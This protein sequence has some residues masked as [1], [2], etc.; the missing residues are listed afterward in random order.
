VNTINLTLY[1]TL[2]KELNLTEEKSQNIAKAI[3]ETVTENV[4]EI[5][6]DLNVSK[7]EAATKADN[8]ALA[9]ATKADIATL[10]TAT[11]ADIAALA[12]TTKA[13]IATLATATK[14]D[15]AALAAT[16]KADIAE[17]K[18]DLLKWFMGGFITI[19]LMLIGLFATIVLRK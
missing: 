1:N 10:A 2:R 6:E 3:Q 4:A 12:A 19:V 9:A 18:A 13:D 16:T 8:A 17:S 11:K 15:I 5:K 7:K 14:A